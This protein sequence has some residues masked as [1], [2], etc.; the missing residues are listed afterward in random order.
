[1]P[2]RASP[3]GALAT[4]ARTPAAAQHADE[5]SARRRRAPAAARRSMPRS[6]SSRRP[7]L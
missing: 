3:G 6:T 1:M 5:W 2:K 7:R 4:F